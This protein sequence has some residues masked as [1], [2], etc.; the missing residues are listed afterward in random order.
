MPGAALL[1][2]QVLPGKVLR[3]SLPDG[4]A[5]TLLEDA[6]PAPDGIAVDPAAVYWTTMG[7]LLTDPGTPGEAGQDFSRPNGGVHAVSLTGGRP[8]EC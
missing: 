8:R 3:V 5:H 2:L 1:A 4:R 7:A 6:G